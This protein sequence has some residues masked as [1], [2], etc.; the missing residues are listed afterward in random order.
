MNKEIYTQPTLE[1]VAVKAEKGFAGSG[2]GLDN[3]NG[4][5]GTTPE[6]EYEDENWD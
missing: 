2:T 4:I 3:N 5:G 1:I 6:Y